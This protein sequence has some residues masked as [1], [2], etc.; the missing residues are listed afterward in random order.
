[1]NH[2]HRLRL[3]IPLLAVLFAAVIALVLPQSA[4]ATPAGAGHPASPKPIKVVTVHSNGHKYVLKVWAKAES[5]HCLAHAHGAQVRHFLKTHRCTHLTRYLVTTK[6]NGRGVGFAQSAASFTAKS[7]RKAFKV[8]GEFRTLISEPG[9]G[10][11]DALFAD[12]DHV[13]S[14]PQQIP[15]HEAFTALS[16][17]VVVTSVDAWYLHG[18]TPDQAKPLVRMANDIFLQWFV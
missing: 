18:N 1:M 15:G 17:D 14:G 12:G 4:T 6:V 9:T 2:D 13:P 16:Q 8:T 3:R 7:E 5:K 10:N 11:F